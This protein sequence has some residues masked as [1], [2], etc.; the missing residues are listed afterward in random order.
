MQLNPFKAISKET[1]QML[2]GGLVGS[3][4]Y[5]GDLAIADTQTAYPAVLKQH[6][7]TFLPRNDELVTTIAPP[8]IM[9]AV[10]KKSA[11]MSDVAK[12]TYLYSPARLIQRVIVN[13]VSPATAAATF[14]VAPTQPLRVM[15]QATVAPA[16]VAPAPTMGTYR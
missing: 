15:P 3:L 2:L 12:G 1:Q 8:A 11:K 16:V 9:W 10:S 14:R 7:A 6:L 13:A 5:W 4:T